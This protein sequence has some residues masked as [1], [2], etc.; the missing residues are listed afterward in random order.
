MKIVFSVIL[1]TAAIAPAVTSAAASK[2]V[3][4]PTFCLAYTSVRQ[5]DGQYKQVAYIT[6]LQQITLIDDRENGGSRAL[7][8]YARLTD[9]KWKLWRASVDPDAIGYGDC[10]R[11]QPGSNKS[12]FDFKKRLEANAAVEVV[13]FEFP[14]PQ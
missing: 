4:W 9:Q 7:S 10:H 13:Q 11:D 1:W 14:K 3:D 8:A 6:Q 12:Y 2:T 5:A